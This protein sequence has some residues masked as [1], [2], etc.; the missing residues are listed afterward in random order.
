[1]TN[2]KPDNK[3][4]ES[5]A[6]RSF[7]VTDS[8][9]QKFK[10]IQ[11]DLDLTQDGALKLLVES[12]EFEAAKNAIP[13]RA[14]EIANFQTKAGELVE[15]FM[16]SLQ[17]NQDAE[18]RIRAEFEFQL[19]TKD[20]A[21]ADVQAKNQSLKDRNDEL[22]GMEQQLLVIQ[23][24]K[25]NLQKEFD[26]FKEAQ[27][28]L[29]KQHEK[30]VS[31]KDNINT[32]LTEKLAAAEN[33]AAGYDALKAEKENLTLKLNESIQTIKDIK[34]QAELE[35]E[36]YIRAS[37]KSLDAA[38]RQAEITHSEALNSLR[39]ELSAKAEKS[40]NELLQ[41]IK[42][43][44]ADMRKAELEKSELLQRIAALESRLNSKTE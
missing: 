41:A 22:L 8:V 7:R 23:M 36:R 27:E 20:E 19:K 21:L 2:L 11:D 28:T 9:L 25:A 43:H 40:R 35:K 17:L 37:E 33:K 4:L 18:T 31:D 1:M 15:A 13:D 34:H 44:S 42:D 32:M 30:Q 16:Y 12:Y 24:E 14:T 10:H 29:V 6:V 5:A 39:S 26:A 3:P 38:L